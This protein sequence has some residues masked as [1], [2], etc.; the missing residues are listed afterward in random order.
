MPPCMLAN[1]M[2]L[3]MADY[4]AMRC[5]DQSHPENSFHDSFHVRI[6][7]SNL[8]EVSNFFFSLPFGLRVDL[9]WLC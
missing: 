8:V 5:L 2:R 1:L 7:R 4:S 3:D 9:E 6:I